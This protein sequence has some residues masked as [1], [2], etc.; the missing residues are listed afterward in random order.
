MALSRRGI[1]GLSACFGLGGLIGARLGVPKALGPGAPRPVTGRARAMVEEAYD[2]L[3]RT[4]I[5]DAHVHIT[6]IGTG[7][8]G[9][10][11]NP[12]SRRLTSPWR[13]FKFDVFREAAGISDMARA[14]AQY[15]ERLLALH[16][17]SNPQGRLVAFAFDYFVTDAGDERPSATEFF[18]P[19]EYVFRLA[20]KNPEIVACASI[21]P[22]R[23]D[24]IERLNQAEAA[25]A[26]AIKW[27]PN[28]MGMDPASS[29]CDA[30]YKRL[31]ELDM[32]LISHAGQELAV[33]SPDAQELGNP[34]RLRRALQ[35]G[36]RVVVAHAASLGIVEDLDAAER[37]KLQSFDAF[38]RLFSE[39]KYEKLLFADIS[40]ITQFHRLPGP[41][42][43]L[44]KDQGKHARLLNGS[45]YPLPAIDPLISTR[46]LVKEGFLRAEDREP[47]NEIYAHNPLLFDFVVKR[48]V[49]HEYNDRTYTFPP[50]VFETAAFFER[51]KS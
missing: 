47:L 13:N 10:W 17:L 26:V 34:L 21:H 44:L 27:L 23:P 43:E 37:Q 19:N 24:A 5:W 12:D 29:Q 51:K 28:A 50:K 18:V 7:G 45:D 20:E 30:F 6:G 25:G 39:S 38:M 8:S 40:A 33:H 22:Y 42:R 3:D 49:S 4:R 41:L 11:V 35:A 32:P 48:R 9:C 14:D 15:V 46:M 31:A 2:G 1:L 16:H 36:V